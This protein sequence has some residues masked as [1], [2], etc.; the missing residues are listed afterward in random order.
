MSDSKSSQR[1]FIEQIKEKLPPH[2]SLVDEIA[3]K[4]N[5]SPDSAY[6][7]I[8]GETEMGFDEIQ[9][10]SNQYGISLDTLLN[11][12][13]DTV[14]FNNRAL[15]SEDFT[16][17]EYQTSVLENLRT[18]EQFQVKEMYYAAKDVPPFHYYEFKE[19]AAFKYYFWQK[20]ILTYDEY[21]DAK[22]DGDNT[23]PELLELGVN[24]SRAYNKVP[25]LEIWSNE[26]ANVTLGQLEYCWESG[27][28]EDK[29]LV[30]MLLDQYQDMLNHI[31]RQAEVGYK[32][33][34]GSQLEGS[35]DNFRLYY[36]EVI[37]PGNTIFFKMGDTQIT[38]IT[39][40]LFNILTTSDQKFCEQ[41][42]GYMKN[43]IQKSSLISTVS[44]KERNK[45]FNHLA[46]KVATV[47]EQISRG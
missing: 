27:L 5:I 38:Y 3:D 23:S 43:I 47:K 36:N 25:S 1:I 42:Y 28:I 45:F 10:L 19:L 8:R 37:I 14:A 17:S 20:L 31:K 30:L 7:R 6:R 32:F 2:L 9:K 34:Y 29:D 15:D 33:P 46:K 26:S 12:K 21:Q 18:L 41:T 16:L 24:I 11:V 39:Y 13:S 35:D 4:L 40:N 44:E 22:F